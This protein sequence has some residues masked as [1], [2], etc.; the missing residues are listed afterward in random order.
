MKCT[1]RFAPR[2]KIIEDFY[3]EDDDPSSKNFANECIM[4]CAY[5]RENCVSIAMYASLFRNMSSQFNLI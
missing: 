5:I 4:C 2:V 3:L 1:R